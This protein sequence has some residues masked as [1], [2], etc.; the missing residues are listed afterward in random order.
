MCTFGSQNLVPKVCEYIKSVHT[1]GRHAVKKNFPQ[2]NYYFVYLSFFLLLNKL[3]LCFQG[4]KRNTSL[5]T[6]NKIESRKYVRRKSEI[7]HD[8][9]TVKALQDYQPPEEYLSPAENEL[10]ASY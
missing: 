5:T 2:K 1:F 9:R 4:E 10:Q 7:P 3:H 8:S 6:T